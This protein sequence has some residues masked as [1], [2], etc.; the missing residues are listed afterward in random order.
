M[1]QAA[2]DNILAERF[3]GEC[4]EAL[5]DRAGARA[6]YLKALALAPGDAQL[7]ARLRA[8]HGG[9]GPP[10]TAAPNESGW[11]STSR[12]IDAGSAPPPHAAD[13]PLAA[14]LDETGRGVAGRP[15]A[16]RPLP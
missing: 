7:V 9:D 16:P 15:R 10:G 6:Q 11:A 12:P 3:L 4:L 13:D 2:P 5:G 14:V 1:L 8:L